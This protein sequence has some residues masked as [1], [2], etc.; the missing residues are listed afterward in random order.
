MIECDKADGTK[1]KVG[2]I[3]LDPMAWMLCMPGFRNAAP[4]FLA[5]DEATIAKVA[6][7]T[8]RRAPI[9]DETRRYLQK[10]IDE[11]A[12]SGKFPIDPG[13][14]FFK[15]A[16]DGTF[17]KISNLIAHVFETAEGY[18][19][20]P[21]VPTDSPSAKTVPQPAAAA[22]APAP[23]VAAAVVEAVAAE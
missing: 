1:C 14:G 9:V 18:G 12:A 19:L 15:R 11:H 2:E 13:T 3:I 16:A 4:R 22:P 17:G 8:A 21:V 20:K 6:E 5:A 7:E 10:K 23:A